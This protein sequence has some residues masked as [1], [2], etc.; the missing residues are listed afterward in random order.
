MTD[1][2]ATASGRAVR[3]PS[4]DQVREGLNRRGLGRWRFYAGDLAPVLPTLAPWAQ[5]FGYPAE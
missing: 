5:R 1:V 3:T 2:A 4:A